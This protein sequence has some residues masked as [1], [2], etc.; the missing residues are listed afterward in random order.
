VKGNA[1]SKRLLLLRITWRQ[2]P[3]LSEKTGR[4]EQY[5]GLKA[6]QGGNL[7]DGSGPAMF[8]SSR[9]SRRAPEKKDKRGKEKG[10]VDVRL[11]QRT[12][13]EK[14]SGEEPN[15]KVDFSTGGRPGRE[16]TKKRRVWQ[17]RG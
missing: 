10:L 14:P 13:R 15:Y 4:A 3:T 7:A 1:R 8:R 16:R 2:Y 6:T 17:Q 9:A 11:N 12:A 5:G